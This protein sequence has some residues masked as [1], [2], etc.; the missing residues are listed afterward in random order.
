MHPYPAKFI[1]QIPN[2]L[3]QE[4]SSVG[5]TVLDPFCGSGTALL[6]A[7]LL[8][9]NAIGIDAS[10]LACLISRAK[11][12]I[13]SEHEL[14]ELEGL[15][16]WGKELERSIRNGSET[17]FKEQEIPS[18]AQEAVPYFEGIDF[19]FKPYV[20]R[21]LALIKAAANLLSSPK[22]R[23][24]ALTVFSAIVV[25]VSN[26][27][28]DTRY[29]RTAKNIGPGE[30]AKRFCDA[31]SQ[32]IPH[33]RELS[34]LVD[35]EQNVKV[36]NEN[37]LMQPNMPEVNLVVTSPPY[38]NAYS[39]HLYHRTRMLWLDMD[40]KTFKRDE[41]GS[42]RKY[43]KNS[44]YRATVQTFR[45][46]LSIVLEW[47]HSIVAPGG[48]VCF[49]IGDSKLR[50]KIVSNDALLIDVATNLGFHLEASI[51]RTLQSSRK[52]FNLAHARIKDEHIV[53]LR[54]GDAVQ[55]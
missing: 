55:E 16:Q 47:L 12:A 1:P 42:H 18:V 44:R 3:I 11:T 26:Q 27:D 53:V 10:P 38:P 14:R 23:D 39:Y 28:S 22:S 7:M 52:S 29:V 13:L 20:K 45:A 17:L 6:E 19:W 24:V 34:K 15:V 37:T 49:V 33:L 54:K 25:P 30:T 5:Q 32:Q 51:I 21:E 41:I 46:E 31:L 4:L 2:L 36:I 9:R 50:G 43:S 8:R 48:F 40:Q 35:D